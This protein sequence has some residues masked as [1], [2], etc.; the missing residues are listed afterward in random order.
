MKIAV[1]GSGGREHCILWRLTRDRDQHD[2][3]ALPGNGGTRNIAQ[4]ID[5]EAGNVDALCRALKT[6][7]PDLVIVGP[8]V[9]LALG[10]SDLLAREGIACFGPTAAAA[11]LEASKVFAKKFMTE[12]DI[13]TA[14]FEVF[15]DFN[16]LKD[17]VQSAEYGDGWVVKADGLAAGK[18]AFV[19]NSVDE[20]L[21]VAYDL[22]IQQSLGSAGNAVVLERKLS[23]QEVSALYCCDGERCFVLPAAQDYKRA[24]D[25]D[26]GQNT[27]GMGSYCPAVHFTHQLRDD[28]EK[29]IVHPVLRCLNA[30]GSP[31]RGL[32]YVG[33][34]LTESGP[35]VIEFNC[36][37]GD[38]ETQV[39]LPVLRGHFGELLLSC[40]E[41]KLD[42]SVA[43]F[44]GDKAAVCVVLAA[45]GYPGPYYRGIHLQS[46]PDTEHTTT[47]HAGTVLTPEGLLSAGG[48]VL[49][50]VGIADS[51]GAARE[52]AYELAQRLLVD[53]LRYRTDIAREV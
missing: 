10:I 53:G 52:H 39:I 5:V 13:P 1:I 36:R 24:E 51:T 37:F 42:T 26:H 23:G 8:E 47:F 6:I 29:R 31:Y 16:R 12:N 18:G 30:S 4:Q 35:Q 17:Y 11:R 21:R 40:A 20:V 27:G 19:C 32:L 28:I 50:A 9:P 48:R 43:S 34:M 14:D 41:G 25:G 49:N 45:K 22:L 38:P 3:F 7:R 33:L 2:L 44:S 15:D 46:V